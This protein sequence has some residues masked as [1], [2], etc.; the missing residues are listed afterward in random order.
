MISQQQFIP[1]VHPDLTLALPGTGTGAARAGAQQGGDRG[2]GEIPGPVPGGAG[3]Y[4]GRKSIGAGTE[5]RE[6]V[7]EQV[8]EKVPEV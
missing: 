3:K 5:D 4:R 6:K 2:C 7:P 8:L 1:S